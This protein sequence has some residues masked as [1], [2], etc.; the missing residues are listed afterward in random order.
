MGA[1]SQVSFDNDD[2]RD[3]VWGELEDAEGAEP[4]AEAFAAVWEPM[5]TWKLPKRRWASQPPR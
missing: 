1:W 4:I 3:W 2:A 5:T